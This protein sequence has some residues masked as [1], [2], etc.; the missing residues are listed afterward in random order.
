M[1]TQP[2]HAAITNLPRNIRPMVCKL[3]RDPFSRRGWI[4][5]IKWDGFRTIA[6]IDARGV[7]LYSRKQ[8]SFTKKFAEIAKSLETLGH[9]VSRLGSCQNARWSTSGSARAANMTR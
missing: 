8:N 3:V 4:F 2:T 1:P 5:E 7:K 9:R 6:E